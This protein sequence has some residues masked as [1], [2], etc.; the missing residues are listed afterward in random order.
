MLAID[1]HVRHV[2]VDETMQ[3]VLK[4]LREIANWSIISNIRT[5]TTLE[6]RSHMGHLPSNREVKNVCQGLSQHSTTILD[7]EGGNKIR[8]SSHRR[9]QPANCGEHD[10]LI[11]PK[12]IQAVD[13]RADA[14]GITIAT[15]AVLGSDE[16]KA[17]TKKSA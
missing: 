2:R 3:D 11:H 5:I 10:V 1:D 9:L 12:D 16:T 17:C 6:Y 15:G 4:N 14:N 8:S 13:I 7:K